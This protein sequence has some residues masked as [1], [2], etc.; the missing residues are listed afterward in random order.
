M[1]GG[2]VSCTEEKIV[3]DRKVVSVA[4]ISG[5]ARILELGRNLIC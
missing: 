5:S 1:L 2:F 3:H 4:E